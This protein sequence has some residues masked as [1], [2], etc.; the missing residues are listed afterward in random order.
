M[1]NIICLLAVSY[2]MVL[3]TGCINQDKRLQAYS[4]RSDY[5][6]P[7]A[8]LQ[9]DITDENLQDITDA[10]MTD[11]FSDLYGMKTLTDQN[12]YWNGVQLQINYFFED[13]VSR[14]EIDSARSFALS[15]FALGIQNNYSVSPYEMWMRQDGSILSIPEVICKVFVGTELIFQDNYKDGTLSGCY[16]NAD[17]YL[18]ARA[19][20]IADEDAL[21]GFIDKQF[22]SSKTYIQ[23]SIKNSALLILLETESLPSLQTTDSLEQHIKD[24]LTTG[25]DEFSNIVLSLKHEGNVFFRSVYG[26]DTLLW[27]SECWINTGFLYIFPKI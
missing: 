20:Q 13:S 24:F 16:E 14:S 21:I 7:E 22:P 18:E 11:F 2:I 8:V 5:Y 12:L 3:C 1:R 25:N 9:N 17:I 6:H 4:E 15:K 23:K 10:S 19:T 27:S 26:T